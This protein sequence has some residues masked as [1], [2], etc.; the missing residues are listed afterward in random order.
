MKVYTDLPN[1][2]NALKTANKEFNNNLK[3]RNTPIKKGKAYQF[4]LTVKSSRD[5]GGRRSASWN[6]DR[7]VSA[8]CWHA[9]GTFFDALPKG[10]KIYTS[11][12]F[13]AGD[14]W[15]DWVIGP[16]IKPV[17]YSDAC[18]CCN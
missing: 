18:D 10:T 14:E 17:F 2:L 11:H 5:K 9:Y 1:I 13:K 3:F 8:A 16:P 12:Y 4:T 7:Y 6:S 15:E